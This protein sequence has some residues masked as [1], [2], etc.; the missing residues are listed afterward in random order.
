MTEQER[1]EWTVTTILNPSKREFDAGMGK[2]AEQL[3]LETSTDAGSNV[4]SESELAP[5]EK[6][7]HYYCSSCKEEAFLSDIMFWGYPSTPEE[8]RRG[9][10]TLGTSWEGGFPM[11]CRP[12]HI[13][14][15]ENGTAEQQREAI[16]YENVKKWK[17]AC[18][19]QYRE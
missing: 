5:E 9:E 19:Q 11:Y 10:Y 16:S 4:T 7:K 15:L 6:R 17:K 14:W 12:C 18:K 3:I 2:I 13:S 8:A 1:Q